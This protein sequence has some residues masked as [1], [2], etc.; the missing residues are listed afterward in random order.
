MFVLLELLRLE[1]IHG[2]PY[3][4]VAG[5]GKASASGSDGWFILHTFFFPCRYN[6]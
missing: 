6:D 2:N 3:T 4:P 1:L 5:K